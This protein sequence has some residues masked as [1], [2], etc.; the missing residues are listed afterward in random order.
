MRVPSFPIAL[1]ILLAFAGCL[2]GG[3][4]GGSTSGDTT[5]PVREPEDD[6]GVLHVTFEAGGT[7]TLEVPFPSLDAC[8]TPENWMAGNITGNA[9]TELR[10]AS[11]GRSGKV[12]ALA[13]TGSVSWSSQIAL[14]PPCQTLGFR[15]D[16]WSI[17]PDAA[18][19]TTEARVSSGS[20]AQASVLVRYVRDTCGNA[21]LYEG[22]PGSGWTAFTGRTIP[23]SCG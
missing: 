10:D 15:Y 7:S 2:G 22:E 14:G 5:G 9:E 23:V 4:G 8:L 12:L 13:G 21:T 3:G 16:P 20:V 18:D 17:D 1:P 6:N 19:G 11:D